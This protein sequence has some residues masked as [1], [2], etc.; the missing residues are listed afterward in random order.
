MNEGHEQAASDVSAM[1]DLFRSEVKRHALTIHDGL[2]TLA[3]NPKNLER[4]HVMIPAIQA[5]KG[6]AQIVDLDL[7]VAVAQSMKSL[8]LAAEKGEFRLNETGFQ[9]LFEGVEILNLMAEVHAEGEQ[10]WIDANVDRINAWVKT[11]TFSPVVQSPETSPPL[12]PPTE[13]AEEIEPEAFS[14]PSGESP[15]TAVEDPPREDD[16]S[17]LDPAMCDLFRTETQ[18]HVAI[19]N[20]G[21]L[22]LEHQPAT[23][24]QL[25]TMMRAAHSLK[26][27]ARIVGLGDA[28]DIAHAMEDCFVAVQKGLITLDSGKADVFFQGI[29]MLN[30]ISEQVGE[31]GSAW[32]TGHRKE[33]QTV[34][35]L[36]TGIAAKGT[37]HTPRSTEPKKTSPP[38][39]E[40]ALLRDLEKPPKQTLENFAADPAMLDLFQAEVETHVAVLND[41]LLALENNPGATDQLEALMR[42]AHSIKGGARIV[43]LDAAVKVAHAMEDCFVAAQK[44]AVL[45]GSEQIDILLRIVDILINIAESIHDGETDWVSGHGEEIDYLMAAMAAIIHGEAPPIPVSPVEEA[46]VEDPVPVVQRKGQRDLSPVISEDRRPVVKEDLQKKTPGAKTLRNGPDGT[47]YRRQN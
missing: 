8:F 23:A 10:P 19:L 13:Q 22:T 32:L 16:E 31:G 5:I 20:D 2:Q 39:T 4:L 29:D 33:I 42:A 25:E 46:P 6:G 45:L 7:A 36:I 21:L 11:A 37:D 24:D 15:A 44:G 47:G 28:A 41:G 9:V 14:K 17:L 12:V 43:G 35:D 26:G 34:K 1:M 3:A 18:N 27:A 30:R 40:K 38:R